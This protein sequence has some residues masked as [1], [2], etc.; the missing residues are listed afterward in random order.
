MWILIFLFALVATVA[1]M[2]YLAGRIGGFSIF[3]SFSNEKRVIKKLIG[4]LILLVI[5]ATLSITLSLV[6]S[7]I[8]ILHLTAFWLICDGCGLLCVRLHKRRYATKSEVDAK[9][10][11]LI[12]KD[13]QGVVAIVITVVYLCAGW[14]FAHHVYETDY[15]ME[16]DKVAVKDGFRI[17]GLADS[18]VGATF[19][20]QEFEGY[21]AKI[22]DL[23]PDLVVISGDFVDDGTSKED[24]IKSC[25]A[26]SKL[27]T[28]YGV[29]FVFG[30]HDKGYY[31]DKK[32]GYSEADIINN[33]KE[34]NV[35]VLEDEVATIKE[36]ITIIGRADR[37]EKNR[38]SMDE[39]L[40]DVDKEDYII[41]LDHQPGDYDN[42]EKSQV[43]LVFSGHTHGGQ[44]I[45]ITYIGEW[46]GI[47]DA[48][49]GF[50]Q[51]DKTSFIDTSG[52]GDWEIKFKTGCIS[53][54]VVMDIN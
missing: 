26:L 38:L 33:L 9:N 11:N 4:L 17:V 13:V 49:Y 19:H 51:R 48:T 21:V 12:R 18:H 22:N 32:R 42:Q 46:T 29:Y 15:S 37:S 39:L 41:V 54:Y 34:N 40:E 25:E 23:S 1:A 8:C 5:F 16:S 14:Y 50:E 30:N 27:K 35:V 44:L 6:N 2:A 7:I 36:G 31:S 10:K 53:E 28:K 45:P 3:S 52:I 43:D 20:W 24:M 47:N